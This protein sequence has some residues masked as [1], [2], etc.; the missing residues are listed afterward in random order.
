MGFQR[1]QLGHGVGLRTQ[2]YAR[3]LEG[4]LQGADWAEVITENFL[5]VGGRPRR[6]LEQLR[7]S[8]PVAL[9]GVNLSIGGTDPLRADYLQELRSLADALEPVWISDHLCWGTYGGHYAHELLPLPYTEESLRHVVGRV[10]EVQERLGR[11]ILLENV[12]AYVE[13]QG[14]QMKE[15]EFLAE[16]A[17]QADCGILLDVNNIWVNARNHDFKPADFLAAI[18][19]DRV[20]QIHLAGHTDKGHFIL[21][22]HIGPV[23]DPVWGLYEDA[24]RRFGQVSTL[25]EWDEEV[26]SWE[27]LTEEP[28]RAAA[29]EARVL[30][31]AR[32]CG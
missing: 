6:V 19:G 29:I 1:T 13:F 8:L 12:S 27:T 2:H 3:V 4:E 18:P 31:E 24:L 25:V 11:Q 20:G 10:T 28:R 14:S 30:A 9:H 32:Q 15:W 7:R 26:P 17:R 23:P 5:G 22:S 16:V 21:D